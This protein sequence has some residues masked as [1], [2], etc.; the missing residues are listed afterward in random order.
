MDAAQSFTQGLQLAPNHQDTPGGAPGATHAVHHALERLGLK[1]A[2]EV[3]V[4]NNHI[5]DWWWTIAGQ[6]IWLA[7]KTTNRWLMASEMRT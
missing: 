6:L 5:G 2:G 4:C 7:M 3:W 1:H